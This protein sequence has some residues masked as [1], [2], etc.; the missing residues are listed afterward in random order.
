MTAT[1]DEN[2]IFA[3]ILR[4]ELPCHKVCE[5]DDTLVIMDVMPQANGHALVLPKQSARN[6]LDATDGMIEA[7]H[8][9]AR[10]IAVA[11]KK[12]FNADGISIMQFNEAAGGQ[13][14]FHLHVHV[15]P[16]F[17]GAALRPHTGQMEDNDILAENCERLKAAL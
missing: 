9:M 1:Y 6:L 8:K 16:R 5:D 4:G 2:N 13:S 14:V 11:S 3:K 7:V 15:I 10:K 17:E 12:A